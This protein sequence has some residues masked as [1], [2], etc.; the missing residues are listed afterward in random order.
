[1]LHREQGSLPYSHE[2]I[3]RIL[4]NLCQ[5]AEQ[6]H[7]RTRA[8][9]VLADPDDEAMVHLAVESRA[10]YIVTHN[11][12]HLEPARELGINVAKPREFLNKLREHL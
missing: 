4:D 1:M 11:I 5:W 10:D 3:E 9:P 8:W 2:E 12:W 6:W 7:L